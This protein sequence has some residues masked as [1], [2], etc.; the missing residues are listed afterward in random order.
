LR[1]PE[2]GTQRIGDAL[3]RRVREAGS[4]EAVEE[5]KSLVIVLRRRFRFCL[6][7]LLALQI[8]VYEL[9]R[10]VPVLGGNCPTSLSH[11]TDGR[12]FRL[13]LFAHGR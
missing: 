1:V 3:V 5:K 10:I 12:I 9:F 6:P 7:V 13:L 11:P 2:E 8:V 4:V